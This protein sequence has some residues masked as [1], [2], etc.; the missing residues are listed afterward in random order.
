MDE[1][2]CIEE[3]VYLCSDGLPG[4]LTVLLLPYVPQ[5]KILNW[6][7]KSTSSGPPAPIP[8][9]RAYRPE[10]RAYASESVVRVNW[11]CLDIAFKGVLE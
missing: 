2:G 7:Q 6:I 3:C 8:A 4:P 5:V 9:R 11:L 10:G 1:S